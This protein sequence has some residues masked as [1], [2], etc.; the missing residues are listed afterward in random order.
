MGYL[1]LNIVPRSKVRHTKGFEQY[2]LSLS[3]WNMTTNAIAKL[4]HV[5]WDTVKD[6]LKS[7]LKKK[8]TNPSL[9]DVTHIG[10]DEIYCGAKSGSMTVV[11]DLKTSAVVYTEKGKKAESLSG[12]WLRKKRCKKPIQAVA[13][14]MGRAY[15]SSVKEHAPE[16]LLVIDRFHVVK[17]F[18]EKLTEYRRKLQVAMIDK[19]NA[20]SLKSTRWLLVSNPENLDE[21]G[22]ARLEKALEM[23][24]PLSIV[25]YLKEKLRQLWCQPSKGAARKWLNE[26]IEEALASEIPI[27]KSFV[28]TLNTHTEGILAYYDEKLTSGQVEVDP[29]G[30]TRRLIPYSSCSVSLP[31]KVDFIRG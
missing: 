19:N 29:N 17:R 4:C 3:V 18:N 8:Y 24:R 26:W 31:T 20:Q 25:Y 14:D 23:N 15:I 21:S 11:V 2:V 7:H 12:F 30:W 5:S 22:Q 1:P 16:A 13:T 28:K 6:I 10:I 27:L 9:T